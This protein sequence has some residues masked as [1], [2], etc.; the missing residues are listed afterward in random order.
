M[1][2]KKRSEKQAKKEEGVEITKARY[3]K[4]R[5]CEIL[6]EEAND[7]GLLTCADMMKLNPILAPV[8]GYAAEK[9]S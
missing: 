9:G 4:L 8:A 6:L 5:A 7:S 1:A 2:N 3:R